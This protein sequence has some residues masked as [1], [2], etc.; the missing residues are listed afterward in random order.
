MDIF[1]DTDIII[2]FLIDRKPFSDNAEKIFGLIENK[3]M[4]GNTSSQ[5]FSNLYSLLRQKMSRVRAISVLRD[6]AGVLS[7]L[8]VDEGSVLKAL[9]SDNIDFENA[10]Q[11]NAVLDYKRIDLI[12]TRNTK[13]YKSSTIPVMSPDTFLKSLDMTSTI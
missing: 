11:Y 12:L 5:T 6:L 9:D 3:K 10:I 4:K 13:D 7:I 2:D 1:L 8:K